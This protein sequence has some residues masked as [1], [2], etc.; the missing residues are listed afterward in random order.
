MWMHDHDCFWSTYGDLTEDKNAIKM[1]RKILS[2]SVNDWKFFT[3]S[4]GGFPCYYV[5]IY[6][7]NL[8]INDLPRLTKCNQ[9][10]S[11]QLY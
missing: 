2:T 4:P 1:A 10:V 7:I 6:V 9:Q 5:V 8:K 3:L 11:V